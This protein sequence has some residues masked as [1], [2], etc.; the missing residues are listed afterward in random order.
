MLPMKKYLAI[1]IISINYRSMLTGYLD[2]LRYFLTYMHI[3]YTHIH[4]CAYSH[5]QICALIHIVQYGL[6]TAISF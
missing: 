6:K 5:T 3:I 4:M 1:S 2:F